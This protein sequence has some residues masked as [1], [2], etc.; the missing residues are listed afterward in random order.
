LVKKL[1]N[2]EKVSAPWCCRDY[3]CWSWFCWR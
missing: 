1:E 2:C 3:L